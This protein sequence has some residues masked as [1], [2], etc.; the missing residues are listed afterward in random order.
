[1]ASVSKVD[2]R[3]FLKVTTAA[4]GGLVVGI[5]LPLTGEAAAAQQTFEPNVFIAVEP[6]G[7]VIFHTPRPEMGQGSRTGLTMIVA[8][9]LEVEFDDIEIVMA[10]AGPREVWGSM[11]A[12]GSTS[13]RLFWEPLGDAAAAAREMLVKAAADRWGVDVRE[14]TA[15]LGKVVH[16]STGRSFGYV[17]LSEA[18]A[19]LPVPERPRRKETREFRYI[20]RERDR[21]DIPEKVDGSAVFGLDFRVPGLKFAVCKR[22]PVIGGSLRGWDDTETMKVGGVRQVIEFYAGVAVVADNTWAALKGMERLEIDWDRGPNAG[23]SSEGIARQ[24][25]RDGQ[26]EPVVAE[27]LRGAGGI[28]ARAPKKISAVYHAPYMSHSPLEP[29]SCI[30]DVKANEADV[31]VSTQAPQTCWSVAEETSGIPRENIRIHTLYTGGAFGRRLTAE[32]VADAVDISRIIGGPV[33]IFWDRAEDTMHGNYR[34]ISRHQME[35]AFDEEGRWTGWRH[36]VIAHSTSRSSRYETQ[37]N[38]GALAGAARLAYWWPSALIEWKM[39]NTPLNTGAWR[40]VY[41]SQNRFATE[42]FIDEVAH[43]LGRDPLELRLELLD[44]EDA[45]LQAVLEKAAEAIGWGRS[46]PPRRGLGIACT[47][48]FGGRLAHAAEVEVE[49]DGTIRVHRVESAIDSGWA[50]YPDGVRQQLEGGVVLALSVALGEEITVEG[51]VVQQRTFSDYPI[52]TF[53]QHPEVNV[54][55]I[56]GGEPIGGV[57]EPPIPPLAPA[58]ANAVFAATGVRLRRMPFGKVEM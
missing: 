40:S 21:V 35:A 54:H 1:M 11:T 44:G 23:L 17:E 29:I 33:Q 57:G 22:P 43:E 58:V 4:A 25:E 36:H 2:R 53:D 18:A 19:A 38:W 13:I 47:H 55:I 31:W 8:D 45:R 37:P 15:R 28:F 16:T 52:L 26:A 27:D 7:R 49:S 51:G 14:C 39:S 32:W 6:D 30:A 48:C 9:E 50:V 12:G 41:E 5:H 46:M 3:D 42:C 20:G 56:D 10:L 34:P 24:L